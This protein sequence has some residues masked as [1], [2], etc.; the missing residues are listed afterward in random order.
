MKELLVLKI[1]CV[2]SGSGGVG[3]VSTQEILFESGL[4][5]GKFYSS[6]NTLI[7]FGYIQRVMRGWYLPSTWYQNTLWENGENEE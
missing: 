5:K 1:I 4:S 3:C 7:E 6:I 2:I